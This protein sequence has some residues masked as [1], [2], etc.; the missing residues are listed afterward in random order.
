MILV[1]VAEMTGTICR[2]VQRDRDAHAQY[3]GQ[4]GSRRHSS[5]FPPRAFLRCP[6]TYDFNAD[7]RLTRALITSFCLRL[8]SPGHDSRSR[9][10]IRSD[11]F[12][13]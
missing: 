12:L 1:K 6:V 11:S 5:L 2:D 9:L 3:Y 7:D 4:T 13:S 10:R 8:V